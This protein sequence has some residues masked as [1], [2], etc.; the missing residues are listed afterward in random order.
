MS[1]FGPSDVEIRILGCLIEK[2]RATPDHYPLTLNSLRLACNQST[3]R[4]P[5]VDYDEETIRK[6]LGALGRRRW[7]RS[8]SGHS[9]RVPKYRHLLEEEMKLTGEQLSILAVLMLR[10]EQ[11]PGE[12]KQRTER[13]FRFP[14]LDSVQLE[15]EGLI[16]RGLVERL[17]RRPGQKEER[18]RQLLGG[19]SD[20]D[21]ETTSQPAAAAAASGALATPVAA[22]APSP[23]AELVSRVEA[24]ERE[25]SELRRE[26]AELRSATLGGQ[27][28]P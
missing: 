10:G 23:G 12:L 1:M 11:T 2:Q 13:L 20:E 4:D 14:D 24:L 8:A 28:A 27:D 22:S 5:V 15:L 6:A 16:E 3:N 18:Y 7:I 9:S 21:E 17:P 26:V 19:G 25:L